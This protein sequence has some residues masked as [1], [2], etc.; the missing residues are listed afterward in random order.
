MQL[1]DLKRPRVYL[2]LAVALLLIGACAVVFQPALQ[3]KVLLDQV[4]PLVDSMEVDYVHVTPWS[5]DVSGLSVAYRGAKLRVAQ[6]A[7]RSLPAKES[8]AKAGSPR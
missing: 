1:S 8:E 2:P 5:L 4:G 6:A 7:L 3:R